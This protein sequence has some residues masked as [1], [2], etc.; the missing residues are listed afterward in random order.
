MICVLFFPLWEKVDVNASEIA[1]IDAISLKYESFESNSDKRQV[2]LEKTT[3]YIG[4]LVM[5]SALVSVYSV[6]QYNNRLR[7]IQLG[8]LNS[9]LIGITLG[10]AI[11][12]IFKAEKLLNVQIQGNYLVG[13]YLPVV[14]LLCNFMANRFIRRDEKLVKSM[15]RIR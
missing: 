7:Q 10:T 8:A 14:A 6:F 5:L 12:F 3:I 15:N 1:T 4:V 2:I 11:F 9:L 13:F